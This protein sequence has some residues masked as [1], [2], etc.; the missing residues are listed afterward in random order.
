MFIEVIAPGGAAQMRSEARMKVL[1]AGELGTPGGVVPCRLLDISRG[2]ACMDAE[3]PQ[4]VGTAV[5]L[6]RGPLSARGIVAWARG[7]RCGMR[8]D[9]PIRATDL[10]VQLSASRQAQGSPQPVSPM[11]RPVSR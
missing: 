7:R 9:D 3:R 10:F 2:G 1:L 4:R 11:P 8:F 5:A 6:Q